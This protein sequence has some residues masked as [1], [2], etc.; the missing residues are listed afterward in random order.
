[1]S[2]KV[3]GWAME[4]VTGSP[5]AKLVLVKLADN[6][7]EQGLCWP[8]VTLIVGHT[9]LGQSTVYKHLAELEAKGLFRV[10]EHMVLP[11][12]GGEPY[13][14][15][16]YQ[17]C[18]PWPS[19]SI[20]PRGKSSPAGGKKNPLNGAPILPG[21]APYKEPSLEPSLNLPTPAAP[22]RSARVERLASEISQA[23][24]DAWFGDAQFVEADPPTIAVPTRGKRSYINQNFGLEIARIFG[25]SAKVIVIEAPSNTPHAK[26]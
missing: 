12:G 11:D 4:Q 20:P 17:L 2:G 9:E 10:V 8:S 19:K 7:N 25:D 15:T 5:A 24:F 22:R 26:V 23:R 3:V 13:R 21:G 6:A 16:A 1:M 14:V 18:L